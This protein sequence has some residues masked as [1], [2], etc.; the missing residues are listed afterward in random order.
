MR[1][2]IAR[3]NGALDADA[4]DVNARRRKIA[5]PEHVLRLC[6]ATRFFR[7]NSGV[8]MP[9]LMQM[10][11]LKSRAGGIMLHSP[12]ESV[13]PNGSLSISVSAVVPQRASCANN[14]CAAWADK[15]EQPIYADAQL[16]PY[17]LKPLEYAEQ[18]EYR[19]VWQVQ[20]KTDDFILIKCPEADVSLPVPPMPIGFDCYL[21]DARYIG[22]QNELG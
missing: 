19:F 14:I 2:A 5:V 21:A 9:K 6:D 17:F 4:F 20:N 16:T 13:A 10:K 1:S 11:V 18:N 7:N 8:G 22:R 3:L 15:I 12:I